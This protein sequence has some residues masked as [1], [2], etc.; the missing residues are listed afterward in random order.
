MKGEI[1]NNTE[2]ISRPMSEQSLKEAE[3]LLEYLEKHAKELSDEDFQLIMSQ[4]NS[5]VIDHRSQLDDQA[6]AREYTEMTAEQE[7][8]TTRRRQEQKGIQPEYFETAD[9]PIMGLADIPLVDI[10]DEDDDYDD[11]W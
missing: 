8:F 1:I 6:R 11:E 10:D 2:R 9:A 3:S 4:I 5:K 7:M